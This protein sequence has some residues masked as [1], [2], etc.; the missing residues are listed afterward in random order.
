MSCPSGSVSA[1]RRFVK[2]RRGI[3]TLFAFSLSFS[4]SDKGLKVF[5]TANR[6]PCPRKGWR[7][8]LISLC[9]RWSARCNLNLLQRHQ[10]I[11]AYPYRRFSSTVSSFLPLKA[12]EHLIAFK[13][14]VYRYGDS[15]CRGFRRGFRRLMFP[16][17]RFAR[18]RYA[19]TF[20]RRARAR[21]SKRRGRS[22]APLRP[23]IT[24]LKP[25]FSHSRLCRG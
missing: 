4:K 7:T 21:L 3:M 2:T 22:H 18:H 1:R 20:C 24:C 6:R 13:G 16:R 9:C 17:R 14:V 15:P 11:A 8:T 10:D 25:F 19:R 12:L 23:T 5:M